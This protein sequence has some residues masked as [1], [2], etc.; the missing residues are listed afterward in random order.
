MK[1][2]TLT[3]ITVPRG[4]GTSYGEPIY[5]GVEVELDTETAER[6]IRKGAVEKAGAHSKPKVEGE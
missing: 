4:D 1:V 3:T 2:R 6:L 5:P